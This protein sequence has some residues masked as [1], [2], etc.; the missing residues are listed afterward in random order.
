MLSLWLKVQ[1]QD[2]KEC[3]AIKELYEVLKDHP[4]PFMQDLVTASFQCN[5]QD[6]F[7]H[8]VGMSLLS[9]QQLDECGSENIVHITVI[10]ACFQQS[11]TC[12]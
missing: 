2:G 11:L 10:N 1:L 9:S 5:Y 6:V 4:N 8:L 3:I 12:I 7:S